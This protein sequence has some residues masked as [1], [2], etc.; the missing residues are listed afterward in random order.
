MKTHYLFT[1]LPVVLLVSCNTIRNT[2][3]ADLKANFKNSEGSE[4]ELSV[5]DISH[6]PAPVQ[7]YFEYCGFIGKPVPM[8]AEVV[9][10]ES[11]IRMRPDKAWMKLKTVQFNSV[12]EPFRIAYMKAN[13]FGLIPFEGRDI[14]AKG[15]GHMYGK[16]A[17]LI[18]VFDE[19]QREIGQSALIIILAEA[20]LVP[21]YALSDY[22]YWEPIDDNS[23][24]ARITHNGY[25][26][27]G[28]FYFNDAGEMLRFES[29]DRYYLSPEKGNVLTKFIATVSDYK[30]QGDYVV[31]GKL[32][33]AWQLDSGLYEYWKGSISEVRYNI[34]L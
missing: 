18:T 23:A 24:R 20:L 26:V 8:N 30:A 4:K 33:A 17:N 12:E 21:G 13:M 16:I 11:F 22:I 19:K 5:E 1:L 14:Y 9:W 25:H 27:S 32:I 31:P 28:I 29:N 2:F 10:A 3:D 15:Q 7:R 34:S 6:L